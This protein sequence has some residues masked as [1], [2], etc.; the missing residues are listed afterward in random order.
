MKKLWIAFE[1]GGSKTR[2]LLSDT[3]CNVCAKEV[4]GTSHPSYI[5]LHDYARK[6]RSLLKRIKR[7]ADRLD[8][9]VTMAGLA[10][11]MNVSLV[12][13]LIREVF[14]P[15]KSLL[16]GEGDIALALY[17]LRYGIS[18][19]AGT[20]A[21]CRYMDERGEWTGGGGLGPQFGDEGSGYWI[22][23]EAVSAAMRA[24]N[25]LGPKTVLGERLREFFGIQHFVEIYSLCDR[26]GHVPTPRI[27]AL[28][29]VVCA[30]AEE[31]DAVARGILRAAGTALG[32]LVVT[33][34]RKRPAA[35]RPIPVV[36]TGGVFCAGR[37]IIGPLKRVL[38]ASSIPFEVYPEVPEPSEGILKRIQAMVTEEEAGFGCR[39]SGVGHGRNPGATRNPKP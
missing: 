21:S 25:G 10:G 37:F 39:V 11:P 35:K 3:A 18:L 6:T 32:R 1:G 26:S 15:V 30:A 31:G 2:I 5:H 9:R 19:V 38:S 12:R 22:G 8:G 36:P 20:G 16:M 34:A 14:G 13:D 17:G 33:V 7:E 4:G 23:R 29:P 28:C 24:E 27:A